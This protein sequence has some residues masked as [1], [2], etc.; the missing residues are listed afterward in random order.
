M[1][2]EASPSGTLDI[3]NATLRSREIVALT[4]MVAGNDVIREGGGPTLEVYGDP[5]HGGN[6]AR[7]ELVSNLSDDNSNSF[8]RLTSNAGV[9]SIQSGTNAVTDGPIT[10]GGFAN[11]RMRIAADGKVGI[12]TDN[13]GALLHINDPTSMDRSSEVLRLNRGS[14]GTDIEAASRGTIGMYL[15]D[16]ATPYEVARMSWQHDG[17]DDS[18]E[19][20]GKLGF[21]TSASLNGGPTERMTIDKDGNVGIGK[22]D[23]G[24]K[25]EV[26]GNMGQN[27]KE[28]YNQLRWE[29]DLTSLPTD[30]FYPIEFTH[31]GIEGDPDLPDMH[32]IH[33]KIFGESL[34]ATDPYNENTLVGYAKGG[35]W[36]DHGPMYDVHVERHVGSET[37]FQG[38]YEGN[39]GYMNGIV[40]YMRGGYRYS[41]LT[42]ANE[43]I[44]HTSAY[45]NG[46]TTF[47]LKDLSGAD[48][49]GTSALI[50]QLVNIAG[51][52]E[53]E[54][55][56]M[57]GT[58]SVSGNV[59]IGTND[60]LARFQITQSGTGLS[61][62]IRLVG[63]STWNIYNDS[64]GNLSL[65]GPNFKGGYISE[66]DD[67]AKIDFTGQH[68]NFIDGIPA[69]NYTDFEGLIV[70]A[71]K[72]KYYDIDENVTTGANAI[73]IS[74]SLPLV[75]LSTTEKDK[76]CFGVISGSEDP[77]SR[78][79]A[80]GS[81]VSVVQKQKGD[82][83]AFIN[84]VGEGAIWV[85]NINGSLESGDYITTSNVAGYGQ[86]QDSEF[87]AN[88]TV[89]KITMDCDFDPVTQPIQI[90]RKETSN[91]N[92]W[93]KTTYENVSEEEYSN[94]ED[95]NRQI[96]DGV[97]QKITNEESKTEQ[98]GYE[99]EVRRELVNVLDEHG[100]IQWEDTDETEKAYKI[101][102]LDADGNLTDEA[103][104]VYKAAF[105]GCTYHCG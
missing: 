104:H 12:G 52:T 97:Y 99:L 40:I 32:P 73:Q 85:T 105:V 82:R 58:V 18:I 86:R 62:G 29:I 31:L 81:F 71:N 4:N 36:S 49:S 66:D 1:P 94:L 56:W 91:V 10:F 65:R 68:R 88:Y 3:E 84:S 6:E 24:Y 74:Q 33:F 17:T 5:L 87:L 25:L 96:I 51:S 27:G 9:F 100:Q 83:R 43:V 98:E 102:Y 77:D 34:G 69:T 2:I 21:W 30:R 50:T 70:S 23:P 11:E 28:I 22:T 39:S 48:A 15:Q 37:R 92:Y 103:N 63:G 44:T 60:P 76:A 7:L 64:S 90:I 89:A 101:R 46:S 53:R 35:G 75:A 79:Y 38:L 78:E 55:R 93:V 57:S 8:T 72:N 59:G 41:A 61:D 67:V 14:D 16:T 95:E 20:Y 54:Q 47:A 42:D 26:N 80:Q 13:P 19:G 45:T